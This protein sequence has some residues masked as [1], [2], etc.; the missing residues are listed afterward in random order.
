MAGHGNDEP[1]QYDY[2]DVVNIGAYDD[3]SE[4][5][6]FYRPHK[7]LKLLNAY[8]VSKKERT[9]HGRHY[10]R[11]EIISKNANRFVV[12][13]YRDNGDFYLEDGN[14]F[15]IEPERVYLD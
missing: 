11:V 14:G 2:V 4:V 9:A 13:R 3:Y 5:T 10:T 7:G 15:W 12:R 1:N 6:I 8:L